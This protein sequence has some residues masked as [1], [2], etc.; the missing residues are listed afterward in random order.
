MNMHLRSGVV[1]FLAGV[2]LLPAAAGKRQA[3]ARIGGQL[4]EAVE[5]LAADRYERFRG[6]QDEISADEQAVLFRIEAFASGCRLFARLS[7]ESSGY[8]EGGHLRTNLFNAYSYLLRFFRDLEGEM[9]KSRMRTY[10]LGNCS[11][12]LEELDEAFSKWPDSENPAYLHQKYV[13][14]EDDAVYLIERR[15]TGDY[16]RRPFSSLESLFRFNYQMNRDKDPW[17]YLVDVSEETLA[18]MDVGPSI[19]LT[20]AG[21]MIIAD[22]K[23]KNRPVYMI[24]NGRRCVLGS[25]A[26]VER[27]GGWKKV[28][29]VPQEII[30]SYADGEPII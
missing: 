25:P 3:I 23:Q 24:R 13:K 8:E 14:A 4:T 26:V 28:Y 16:V 18:T 6:N 19:E 7:A 21:W 30:N 15:G 11:D 2:V 17:K 20:F 10:S 12:L 27:F 5:A 29:A 9:Q 22:G 1:L